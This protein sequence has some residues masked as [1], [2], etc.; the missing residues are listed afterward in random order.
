[1]PFAID[2][3][4]ATA[5]SRVELQR[6]FAPR[7]L[8]TYG[9]LEF[10]SPSLSVCDGASMAAVDDCNHEPE[11]PSTAGVHWLRWA[12]ALTGLSLLVFAVTALSGP[13]R[14]DVCDGQ[15]RYEVSR[16]L[17]DHGDCIIRDKYV[18]FAVLPGRD[19]EL[20]TN[21]RIPHSA[22]GVVT[23]WLA[24]I[25]GPTTE[26]RRQ[27]FFS[28]IGSLMCALLAIA[29]ALWF[30]HLGHSIPGSLGWAAAGIFCTPNW[31]YATS[32]FDDLLAA[33]P[34]VA[35]VVAAFLGRDRRPLLGAAS[36]GL[37][38]A[39]AFNFKQP[40]GAFVFPVLAACYRPSLGFNRQL[41]PMGLALGGL[42]LGIVWQVGYERY[43]FPP[44]TCDIDA[45]VEKN[46]GPMWKP[47]PAL[48]LA[49]F[50]A[51]PSAG[52]FWH[53]PTL[54]LSIAGWFRW[55]Q[56]DHWFTDAVL[57][58]S[59]L[60]TV[61]L[62]FLVFFKGE[63]SWGPRYL[64]PLFAL[65]WLFAPLA[66]HW[67]RKPMLVTVLT[68][69]CLVQ[70]LAL[71]VDPLRLFHEKCLPFD[72]Y[73]FFPW[74]VFDP[75]ASHLW[76]RPREILVILNTH[77]REPEFAPG[78]TP[79][80]APTTASRGLF[81]VS[82]TLGLLASLP[83]QTPFAAVAALPLRGPV[84]ARQQSEEIL[85]R[86]HV[87]SS[88]RPWWSSQL[89]LSPEERP[90]DFK[91]ALMFLIGLGSSGLALMAFACSHRRRPATAIQYSP[92]LAK[93]LNGEGPWRSCDAPTA[94]S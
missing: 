71:S 28:F 63:P 89:Y 2:F 54:V 4:V 11:Q 21:Y 73:R 57:F 61:F 25:T 40:M 14:I 53:C 29:Y 27:F 17:V 77:E 59:M 52:V 8:A 94:S 31:Y 36:A 58:S 30:R 13:G 91:S 42:A 24:D 37:L 78:P 86:Y 67:I 60:F 85:R 19:G 56:K 10:V 7:L 48:G 82:S 70:L 20:H 38:L 33:S 47:I 26:T 74:L 18:W 43:K 65:W 69:G 41:I 68:A 64:T 5:D 76:Q 34:G 46:Y 55:R 12:T 81:V 3:T 51:S 32:T 92:E 9:S 45:M 72:Y 80:Y 22:M 1:V 39:L 83:D 35:A 84:I 23:I 15:T 75:A 66:L 90:V 88:F 6:H 50:V 62:C 87:F 49:S 79:T 44:D 16:S 93:R